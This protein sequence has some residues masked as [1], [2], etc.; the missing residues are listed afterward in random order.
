MTAR[1]QATD[2]DSS[3]GFRQ[4]FKKRAY[5]LLNSWEFPAAAST[6]VQSSGFAGGGSIAIGVYDDWTTD[7]KWMARCIT[8]GGAAAV[9][10]VWRSTAVDTTSWTYD[11]GAFSQFPNDSVLEGGNPAGLVTQIRIEITAAGDAF[12]K[13]DFWLWRTH[14]NWRKTRK[15]GPRSIQLVRG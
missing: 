5:E 15:R 6:P 14:A 10:Q 2:Q 8:A 11:L 9:F 12:V 3:D 7:A 4:D 13:G 1:Y